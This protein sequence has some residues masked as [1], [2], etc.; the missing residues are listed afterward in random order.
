MIVRARDWDASRWIEIEIRDGMLERIDECDRPR[1]GGEDEVFVAPAFWDIQTNGRW[2]HSFSSPDVTVDQVV[3]I[4]RAQR[5]LG[6]ARICPTLITAPVDDTLH[7]L[8]TVAEAC[9]SHPDVDRMVVGVHLEGPFLSDQNGYKGT[10]PADAMRDPDWSLFE[11]FQEASGGRVI[12]M[13]LAPERPG[14]AEFIRKAVASGVTVSVGHTAVDRD[15]LSE[16]VEAGAT[17]STHLGNGIAA[18]LPRHP[19]PI[20]LQAA[21]DRLYASL[22]ADGHH[23]DREVLRVLARAKGWHRL[24]L[25]SDAGWLAGLPAGNYGAWDVDPSGKIVLAGTP[26]LA[27]STQGLETGLRILDEVEPSFPR[28]LLDTVTVNPARLLNQ[29]APR[30]AVGEPADLTLLRR[31]APGRLM[32]EKTCVGGEWFERSV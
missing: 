1:D 10:H 22:I 20:W 2:G 18:E 14:S 27:G 23:L 25:V 9:D 17:L 4:I 31:P 32:L 7:G 28:P 21:E 24:I 15:S 19:N 6:A 3:S 12:L 13:T 16:A 30:L 29:P 11:R 26:Y 8:R 5:G